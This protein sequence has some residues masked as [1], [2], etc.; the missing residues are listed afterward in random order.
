MFEFDSMH[1]S[2]L[3]QSQVISVQYSY[4]HVKPWESCPDTIVLDLN[5]SLLITR[6]TG[7]VGWYNQYVLLNSTTQTCSFKSLNNPCV[8]VS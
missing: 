7:Y 5:I 4:V 8:L 3:D 6:S 1:N 2:R